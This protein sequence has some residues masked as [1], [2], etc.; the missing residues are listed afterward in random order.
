MQW[1]YL[2]TRMDYTLQDGSDNME[3]QLRYIDQLL[4]AK[5]PFLLY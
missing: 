5:A 3:P 2:M 4:R 1:R